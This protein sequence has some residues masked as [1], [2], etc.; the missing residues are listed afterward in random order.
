MTLTRPYSRYGRTRYGSA[1]PRRIGP[2]TY[3]LEKHPGDSSQS[4]A[5][6]WLPTGAAPG[7]HL[8]IVRAATCPRRRTV[9]SARIVSE[10]TRRT[11][12]FHVKRDRG[13][14]RECARCPRPEEERQGPW[15]WA[16]GTQAPRTASEQTICRHAFPSRRPSDVLS[17]TRT[18]RN[19]P[20]VVRRAN[21]RVLRCHVAATSGSA[22]LGTGS[23]DRRAG[24][25][26]P[27]GRGSGASH[28]GSSNT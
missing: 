24:R 16:G 9:G 17:G 11:G 3:S 5:K 7:P 10:S 2:L 21:L 27:N 14:R 19:E 8:R 20:A 12:A 15:M 18:R 4:R 26:R 13:N 1:L 22:G 23:T 28:I 6:M 25:R